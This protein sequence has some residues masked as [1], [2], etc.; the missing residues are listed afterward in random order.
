M[1]LTFPLK[2]SVYPTSRSLLT[3][4]P[5]EKRVGKASDCPQVAFE[6]SAHHRHLNHVSFFSNAIVPPL[7][8]APQP[9]VENGQQ[10]IILF[11]AARSGFFLFS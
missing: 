4:H 8:P 10:Y 2:F 3:R 6:T 9:K 7:C 5:V 11:Q 1:N